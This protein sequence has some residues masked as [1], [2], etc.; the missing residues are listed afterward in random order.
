LAP[1]DDAEGYATFQSVLAKSGY[2]TARV[3]FDPPVRRGNESDVTLKGLVKLGC[4]YERANA[5]YV[6]V[7]IPPNA[8]LARVV[9]YLIDRKATWEHA[10]PTYDDYHAK[11]A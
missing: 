3:F 4:E 9:A 6:V 2:R 8:D 1:H 7:S 5:Q 11:D 10:D